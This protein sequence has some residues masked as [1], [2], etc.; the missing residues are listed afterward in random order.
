MKIKSIYTLFLGCLT[1]S[2]VFA[3][4]TSE[5]WDL[6]HT[7]KVQEGVKAFEEIIDDD[8]VDNEVVR[9]GAGGEKA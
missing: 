1:V 2:H 9:L 8:D 5:A 4:T 7:N 6:I 3:G